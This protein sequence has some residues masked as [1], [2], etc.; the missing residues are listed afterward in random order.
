MNTQER[1]QIYLNIERNNKTGNKINAI[2]EINS[3]AM[4]EAKLIDENKK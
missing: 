2:L 4:D 1:L 3:N